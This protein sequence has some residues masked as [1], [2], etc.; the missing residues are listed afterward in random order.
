MYKMDKNKTSTEV[1]LPAVYAADQ[2]NKHLTW[3]PKGMTINIV[4]VWSLHTGV[5]SVD[6]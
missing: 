1:K 2:T 6:F 4:S 5:Y 3:Q